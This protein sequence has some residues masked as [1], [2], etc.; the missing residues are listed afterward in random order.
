MTK[1]CVLLF[2]ACLWAG[3]MDEARQALTEAAHNREGDSRREAALA[4]SLVPAKD[5]IFRS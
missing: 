3:P 5:P 4:L 1:V 2:S